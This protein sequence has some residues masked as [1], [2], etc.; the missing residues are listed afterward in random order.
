MYLDS[1]LDRW[2]EK[3][4]LLGF[5]MAGR[6]PTRALFLVLVMFSAAFSGCFGETEQVGIN[7]EKDVVITPQTLSGGVFQGVT[8]T[9]K[10]DLSAYIPYLILNEDNGFVQNST[11]VD[12]KSG[13]SIQ[14]N[15]LAPPRTDT[16]VILLGEYGR[17][18]WPIRTIDESWK[19]WFERRGYDA[20]DNPTVTRVS[21]I[22]NSL[23]TIDYSNLTTDSVA[24]VKLS[25]KRQMAAA[26]SES[27]G[28]RH[29]MGI[30]DGRTVFNYINIMSDETPDLD[31]PADG[32]VGYLDRWAGQGNLAY[33]DAAQYLISTMEGFGLEV[34][35]QR[36]VY[37]SL[38]TGAQNPEAY[39]VCGYRFGEVDPDKWMV[40]GAH[41]DIAPPVNGG[42]LDPHIFGRT[43]GT[44]VGA[45]DN[46]AG[47]SMV[48]T[49][50]EA[51]AAYS[52]RNTM[53]FCLWSG[54][55]GG[56]RGS[57][58]WTDYWVKEDNP[59]V[60][61]AVAAEKAASQTIVT[62]QTNQKPDISFSISG[63]EGKASDSVSLSLSISSSLY[64]PQ[65]TV[66]SAR[67]TV[68]DHS[69]AR[70]DLEEARSKAELDGRS[71][72]R[73]WR[74]A[75][76]A[77]EAVKSEIEASQLAADGIRNEVKFGLKTALD[78]LDAE[79]NVKDAEIRLVSAEHDRL[80]AELNLSAALGILTSEKLNLIYTYNDFK[81]LP[82]PK[83][84]LDTD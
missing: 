52:T 14:L 18:L 62:M 56:K 78:L 60:L 57:D 27:E 48:L 35:V 3:W 42:M 32:A 5:D 75:V 55:E 34:I 26:F 67:K 44:R 61:I 41:F 45:Y 25:V 71:A 13:E 43:Y 73:D 70:I 2:F 64:D 31:D 72:F 58:F 47:T 83:N 82:R 50:A 76:T 37:D 23:D 29:S 65:S 28:G 1:S 21:A 81:I 49:V 20:E 7:S 11:V 77:L 30:V 33:E 10:A 69:K 63:T 53:V 24:V 4:L 36:F 22:N 84:P 59:N 80:I 79:K 40:F 66:A 51:M 19:T 15:I 68:S 6:G 16:A 54:E 8:I 12:L 17:D 74:A 9:A 39:N 46:T 38:M